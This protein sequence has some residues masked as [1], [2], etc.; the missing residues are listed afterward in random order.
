MQNTPLY[1]GDSNYSERGPCELKANTPAAMLYDE[2][3]LTDAQMSV[4]WQKNCIMRMHIHCYF[5]AYAQTTMRLVN[6]IKQYS[7]LI[8]FQKLP[9]EY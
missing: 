1:Y 6:A 5:L 3:N 8:V 9:Q 7:L 2:V 4:E